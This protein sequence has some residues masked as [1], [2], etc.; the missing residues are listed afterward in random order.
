MCKIVEEL[1][2]E[3]DRER[4]IINA[5]AMLNLGKL[6]YEEIAQCSGLTL[7]EVKVLAKGMPA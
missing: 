6:S 2:Y 7:E 1:R 3:A 5:K 4:M